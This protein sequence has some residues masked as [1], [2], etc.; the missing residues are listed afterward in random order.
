[1]ANKTQAFLDSEPFIEDVF[2]VV[3][4]PELIKRALKIGL[5]DESQARKYL[6][7]YYFFKKE[8]PIAE[9]LH[10]GKWVASVNNK[11]IV[12]DSRTALYGLISHEADWE[13]AY[14]R[15]MGSF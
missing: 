2:K 9:A 10:D 6:H 1:M 14:I 11:I 8:E 13:R 15:F 5:I 7:N 4:A 3:R 12:A